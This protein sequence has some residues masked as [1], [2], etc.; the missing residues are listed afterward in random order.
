[1]TDAAGTWWDRI[2]RR[3]HPSPVPHVTGT[4][5]ALAVLLAVVLSLPRVT[6]RYFGL[7]ATV[8]AQA[9]PRLRR[10][11]DRAA[12]GRHPSG[13]GPVRAPP[14]PTAGAPW[15]PSGPH[16]GATRCR[17]SSGPAWSG[18]ASMDGARQPCRWEPCIL[19]ASFLF[20]RNLIG[21][22]ITAAAVLACRSADAVCSAG[23]HRPCHDRGSAWPSWSLPS[24][25]SASWPPSTCGAGTGCAT[26]G[27]YLLSRATPHPRGRVDRPVR[28]GGRCG[29]VV[30]LAAHVPGPRGRAA[31]TVAGST[32]ARTRRHP[33]I[34]WDHEPK[35]THRRSGIQHQG[36]LCH[37]RREFTRDTNYIE[38]RIT[39]EGTPGPNGEPGW[40]VEPGRYR[41]IAARAC[42]GPT[43]P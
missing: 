14:P 32:V 10:A 34:G 4:E 2:C 21:L 43:G 24:G 27:A 16:S 33:G 20:I 30:R 25:T 28:R 36:R 38:D 13:P 35:N 3:L 40:P 8:D 9:R 26:S 29:L 19:L 15:R 42:P 5:L 17:P 11:D 7:L 39:R 23:I 37:G 31:S 1:M 18:A 41:L 6:W 22:L 12:R